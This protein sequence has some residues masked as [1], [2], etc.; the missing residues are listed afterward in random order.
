MMNPNLLFK[1]KISFSLFF[2][3]I[4]I[5][6]FSQNIK[7]QFDDSW[8]KHGLS[9]L[10]EDAQALEINF[11]LSGFTLV[12]ENIKAEN[13]YKVI[14][15]GVLLPN[16]E[17]APDVPVI[18]QYIAVPQGAKVH[19]SI[20]NVRTENLNDIE[21]APAPRIPF[22]TEIGPLSY[23]KDPE[24]FTKNALYPE[25]IIQV[26]EP[27][28][29][30]GVDVV[31]IAFSPFQYNPVTRELIVNRDI[32]IDVTF[33]GGNGQFGEDRLRNRWWDAIIRDAV[34]NE[35]SIPEISAAL[36]GPKRETGCEYLIISPDDEDFLSW[37]DS[38]RIFRTK[39]GILTNVV[40]TTE[41]GGNSTSVIESYIN[42]A[43]N[44]W[45]I[46]PAAVLLMADYGNS[47]NSITSPIYDSYCISD[48]IYAD[49]DNDHLPDVIFARMT[50]Q[51]TSQLEIMVNK[52][53]H[54][55]RTPPTNPD[56]YLHPIS[57]MGWQTER[58]FQL[59]SE[60]VAGYFENV[61]GKEVVRE[62][63][64]YDG[65]PG[66]GIWSTATNT[67]TILNVFGENGLGYIP[68]N[69][70]YLTDWGGNATRINND[71][72]S[73]AFLLQHRDH[74]GTNGWGEPDY[75]NNDINGLT[76]EDLS[77]IFSINCLTG[78]FNM[79][80]E[81]F[82]EKFH[83]HP[84]GALGLIA[85]TE[86]SYSFVNDAYVWGMYDNMWPD[87]MPNHGTTPESRDVLPAFGN[88]AGKYFLQQSSWPYNTGN[89][90]VTYYLFHHH[91]DAFS[92]V[93]YDIPQDLNVLHD[94]V[95]LSGLDV[96][97]IQVEEGALICLSVGDQIIG[98]A[99]GTGDAIEVP[100]IAQEPGV[101]VDI[102]ITKQNFYRFESQIEVIPPEGAYCLYSEH[103]LNDSLGNENGIAE[104]N[105][106]IFIDLE[107]KNLGTEGAEDVDI[108][109]IT[110]DPFTSIIDST[111]NYGDI[112]AGEY[113][114]IESAFEISLSNG[115]PDQHV[116]QIDIQATDS[117]DS[118]WISKFYVTVNAPNLCAEDIIIDDSESGNDNGYLD[119]GETADIII[120]MD[121]QGH[122]VMNDI[123]CSLMAYNQF[124]TVNT[125]Q[126][127]I[128]SLDL[129]TIEN[130]T[131]NVTVSEE[132]PEAVVAEMHFNAYSSGYTVDK[133][134]YPNIG[135][136][137][138]DWE[139]GDFEKYDWELNGSQDW[140]IDDNAP[141][142][143]DYQA[144][145]GAISHNSS[146]S[147]ELT[148]EVMGNNSSI[149]FNKK[150]SSEANW[151]FLYFYI[152]DNEKGKWSG[153]SFWTQ[154][155]YP[156]SEG[157]H[158]FKWE[159]KKDGNTSNGSD[160]AWID[161]I[162]LPAMMTTTLFAGPDDE[163]C[164]DMPYQC[165]GVATNYDTIMWSTNGDGSFDTTSI[166][167]PV[168]TPGMADVSEGIV[169]LTMTIIDVE[170]I[171]FS[172]EMTLVMKGAPEAP[173]AP[174]GSDYVDVYKVTETT[175]ATSIIP[176]AI[177]YVW[178]LS[179]EG[180]GEIVSSD[181][182]ATVYW[183]TEYLGEAEVSVSVINECGQG[184]FSDP[185]L[186]FVDNTVSVD[187]MSDAFQIAVK[188]NPN[189]GEF[190]LFINTPDKHAVHIQLMNYLGETI[191]YKEDVSIKD[192]FVQEFNTQLP[193]G[194]Y[195][196]AVEQ[197]GHTYKRKVIVTK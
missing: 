57:A 52:F 186:I 197:N 3:S 179:P 44:N 109:I 25:Q 116:I 182:S 106:D 55:E 157:V 43:Y 135:Q 18:S 140:Y 138:E 21:I 148:Y 49:I 114:N 107:I 152:D 67:S 154:E 77:F 35:A 121:N 82:A 40:T 74:G 98:L 91:G 70:G 162:E 50:A 180:A 167:N 60:I 134:Y 187:D 120:Q 122:A 17:G 24:I 188:P 34:F 194:L 15:D 99:V 33:E 173:S 165:F 139:T 78:K 104:I 20:K 73:G 144:R 95:L 6:L 161:Y 113:V 11:S 86:V 96:Y 68:N 42:D 92:T 145:S 103:I 111:E 164:S 51:N 156:V 185:I 8:G 100:I 127:V 37:A 129:I 141:F 39:Q 123:V 10:K 26:S 155:S 131:F 189:N 29:I 46:P 158:T 126:Q 83:R 65:N 177:G 118:S 130:P 64:I 84:Y 125:D 181:T 153:N 110:N 147:F 48:N 119:P 80:G 133:I 146:T 90:E 190:M 61:H 87:F 41:I 102:V 136:F 88:A 168:Y 69:P 56:F 28:K 13:Y 149:S 75:G 4:S 5:G 53:L 45:D 14:M 172:D 124:I 2:L 93:Y 101:L 105:E 169:V 193:P 7:N 192:Q 151:D 59:C 76:N 175:Y 23:E 63:A 38:I 143:G 81:C 132:A 31:L 171:E 16:D 160:C 79:S 32:Q 97:T 142:E 9:L 47:G 12:E 94:G 159:Y 62:N 191:Y 30:R 36:K 1:L 137:I 112:E 85:A 117:Q 178:E 166:L 174:T 183:N 170:E 184:A 128:P 22:D 163:V 89:K 195:I 150:V 66:G 108:L 72:N 196:I 115:I 19:A 27:M 54:Y 71:I 58:W 176:D